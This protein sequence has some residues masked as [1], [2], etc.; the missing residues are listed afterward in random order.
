MQKI[1]FF[2]TGKTALGQLSPEENFSS[3]LALTLKLTQTQ[4]P[5]RGSGNFLLGGIA[6]TPVKTKETKNQREIKNNR[7]K[8]K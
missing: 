3:I 1:S 8:K 7:M 6:R 2:S 5:T 4:T